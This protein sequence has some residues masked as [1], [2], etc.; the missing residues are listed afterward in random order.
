ME[1]F[2][3]YNLKSTNIVKRLIDN[4]KKY[5][6]K[7]AYIFLKDGENDQQKY[8]YEELDW[9]A[10]LIGSYLQEIGAVGQRVILLYP[11]GLE[12]IGAFFG[13]LY[14]GAIAVPAYPPDPFRL[15][16]SLKRFISILKDAMPS[17]A[18]TTSSN[19]S[20]LKQFISKYPE[21]KKIH[22]IATDNIPGHKSLYWQ[23]PDINSDTIAYLQYTSGSTGSPKGVII[24]HGNT[25]ANLSLGNYLNNF[26]SETRVAGWVPLYHDLGLIAYVMGTVYNGSQCIFMSPFHFLQ[27]PI[28]WLKAITRFQTSHNAAPPFGYELCVKKSTIQERKNI[29]IKC[30]KVAG[31]GAETIRYEVIKQ[32]ADTFSL[33][34]FSINSFYPTYGMAESV[35]Y[36]SGGYNE[37]YNNIK[38]NALSN[39]LIIQANKDDQSNVK[40][41]ICCGYTNNYHQIIIVDPKAKQKLKDKKVGEI[42]ITG[43]S[44]A[45]G[46]FN[47]QKETSTTFNAYLSDNSDVS[48]L[49]T[50]DLGFINNGKLFITG[51]LKDIIIIRGKNYYPQDIEQ[52]VEICHPDLRKGCC[53]VFSIEEK[54]EEHL[55]ILQELKKNINHINE[56][57]IIYKIR[58]HVSNEHY[59][60]VFAIGLLKAGTIVKTSSGKIQ[61]NTCKKK[62]LEKKITFVKLWELNN[63][64]KQKFLFTKFNKTNNI[65]NNT[66]ITKSIIQ[67]LT[68]YISD[69]SQINEKNIDIYKSIYDYG[70]D[71]IMIAQILSDLEQWLGVIIEDSFFEDYQTI[72]RIA[73]KL[74]GQVIGG[75]NIENFY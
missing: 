32:F 16:I 64:K 30:W 45:K 2:L 28:R 69:M 49:R 12:Y 42:W 18:L 61:R 40:K 10:R 46:Y 63:E 13:C 56:N 15:E 29:D 1:D 62:Y 44:V 68:N 35:L 71:S 70:V 36:V 8:S 19:I 50:G 5:G 39:G 4:V 31:I 52:T 34:G 3:G 24:S 26:S 17:A 47:R 57:E 58:E 11:S 73:K 66:K 6:T 65:D 41:I 22:W 74:A 9:T 51:R 25:V 14:A 53:A 75:K 72:E 23:Y 38:F 20:M 54:N 43:P 27:K 7:T 21:F 67:W 55:I 33:N 59:L 48:Y 60:N 37:I